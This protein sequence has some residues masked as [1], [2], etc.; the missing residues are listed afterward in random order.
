MRE[1]LTFGGLPEI[2]LAA[3]GN[4]PLILTEYFNTFVQ[5]DIIQR[6]KIRNPEALKDLIRLILNTKAYTYSK[7]ANT[8]KSLGHDIGKATV[9]RY[10]RYLDSSF[11][12]SSA[13]LCSPNVKRKIQAMKK[14]YKVDTFFSSRFS[15]VFSQNL[16]HLMEEA[17]WQELKRRQFANP[18]LELAYWKNYAHNEV[19]FVVMSRQK[20]EEL[21]QVTY[22]TAISDIDPR[23]TN[24]LLKAAKE[25]NC[26]NLT[27]LTW[28]VDQTISTDGFTIKCIPLWKWLL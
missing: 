11:F 6:Y 21:I 26:S 2:V 13:E 1:Y 16:G 27:I 9:I 19:D 7:L 28:E 12:T 15:N 25:L 22:A 24:A 10:M 23:E 8:L 5:R 3:E 14:I 4:K 20:A 18:L 17:A